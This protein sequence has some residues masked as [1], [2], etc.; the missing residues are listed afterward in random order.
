MTRKR[1]ALHV[2]V[3]LDK[4]EERVGES[5]ETKEKQE[6]ELPARVGDFMEKK[7]RRE[8]KTEQGG[9][10]ER[11]RFRERERERK[12]EVVSREKGIQC[13]AHHVPCHRVKA[14]S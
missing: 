11:E 12:R 3:S 7:R 4:W 14:C 2:R 13:I 1:C 6:R 5:V 9:A 8:N 10:S